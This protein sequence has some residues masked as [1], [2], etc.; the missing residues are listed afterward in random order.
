M[1]NWMWFGVLT[2]VGIVLA[3]ACVARGRN[4]STYDDGSAEMNLQLG[5]HAVL[6]MALL[7]S[8]EVPDLYARLKVA[9]PET[10]SASNELTALVLTTAAC[11][12]YA[13][14]LPFAIMFAD[15]VRRDRSDASRAARK[16][17]E[18][19]RLR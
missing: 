6:A 3:L 17:I 15:Y 19:A 9:L 8:E 10:G 7:V 5:A 2:V 13:C 11:I 18:R 16:A 1:L 14:G 12:A 4:R